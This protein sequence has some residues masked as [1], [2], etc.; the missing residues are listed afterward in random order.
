LGRTDEAVRWLEKAYDE[1]D[2][3]LVLLGVEPKWGP[4]R[5][6]VGYMKLL[7]RMSLLR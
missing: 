6:T 1:K 3:H 5:G 2:A 7:E 4:L